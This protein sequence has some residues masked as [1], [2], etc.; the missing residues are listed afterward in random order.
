MTVY[1]LILFAPIFIPTGM[2]LGEMLADKLD[3]VV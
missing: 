3:G 1:L 2:M